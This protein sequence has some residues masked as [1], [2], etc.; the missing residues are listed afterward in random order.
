MFRPSQAFHS[1]GY[2]VHN[3]QSAAEWFNRHNKRT[4]YNNNRSSPLTRSNSTLTKS[5]GSRKPDETVEKGL[6]SEDQLNHVYTRLG[7]DVSLSIVFF[8]LKH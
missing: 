5:S 8:I 2:S 1:I 7:E 6:P 4:Y 3:K